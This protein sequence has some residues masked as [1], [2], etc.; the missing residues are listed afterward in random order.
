MSDI[1][2][3]RQADS[4]PPPAP[5]NR[6]AKME[7]WR[8]GLREA[9][10]FVSPQA[11]ALGNRTAYLHTMDSQEEALYDKVG[12]LV[13]DGR[14]IEFGGYQHVQ[15]SS[16]MYEESANRPASQLEVLLW[17]QAVANQGHE[18]TVDPTVLAGKALQ[19]VQDRVEALWNEYAAKHPP[20][21]PIQPPLVTGEEFSSD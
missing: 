1:P 7:R 10:H 11:E 21:P 13:R 18:D 5:T 2:M 20:A 17:S 8:H 12:A 16:K 4:Q 6:A 3:R 14:A 19:E 15:G 9:L